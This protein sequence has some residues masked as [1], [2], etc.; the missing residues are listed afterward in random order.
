LFFFFQRK[1]IKWPIKL[2]L[3]TFQFV[4]RLLCVLVSINHLLFQN[5]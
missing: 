5:N 3:L 2:E 1:D 4:A